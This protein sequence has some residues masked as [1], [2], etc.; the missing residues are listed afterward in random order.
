MFTV[1]L[2]ISLVAGGAA[3]ISFLINLRTPTKMR[4]RIIYGLAVISLLAAIASG[5]LSYRVGVE[6]D[7][8]LRRDNQ[9]ETC[10]SIRMRRGKAAA[11]N[12]GRA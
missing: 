1:T 9:R 5:V 3:F 11:R 12:G 4:K 8:Q 10:A 6:T 2:I 7:E